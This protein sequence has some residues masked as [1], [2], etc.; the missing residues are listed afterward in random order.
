MRLYFSLRHSF[1][2]VA[3]NPGII[4]FSLSSMILLIKI[5][6]NNW[7]G[8]ESYIDTFQNIVDETKARFAFINTC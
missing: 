5:T 2:T 1:N 3:S 7:R 8:I 6:R 4:F